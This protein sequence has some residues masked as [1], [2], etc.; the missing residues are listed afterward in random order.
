LDYGIVIIAALAALA[1]SV[2]VGVGFLLFGRTTPRTGNDLDDLAAVVE[3]Q[4]RALRRLT[5]QK[6]RAAAGDITEG[7][8]PPAPPGFNPSPPAAPLTKEE[9]RRRVFSRGNTQ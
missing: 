3:S 1:V 4:G 5:M 8:A 2:L 7:G 9:L 6:V